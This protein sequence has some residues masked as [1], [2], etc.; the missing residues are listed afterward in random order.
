MSEMVFGTRSGIRKR[1]KKL[2][3]TRSKEQVDVIFLDS[4]RRSIQSLTK[5][6]CSKL[7]I[8]ASQESSRPGRRQRVLVNGSGSQWSPVLSGVPQGSLLEP[9]LSVSLPDPV[10]G[11]L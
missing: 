5:G 4:R 8:T 11:W 2:V 3:T 1:R 9:T 7:G 6:S 10:Y